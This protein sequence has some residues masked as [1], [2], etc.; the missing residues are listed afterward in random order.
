MA[1]VESL[2]AAKTAFTAGK[3]AF[4]WLNAKNKKFTM[5][6]EERRAKNLASRQAALGSGGE[7]MQTAA[8][9]LRAQTTDASKKVRANLFAA[10]LENSSVARVGQERIQNL[11]N[12]QL[13][14]LALKIADRNS[15]FLERASQRKE[16]INMQIGQ[17]R[18]QFEEGRKAEMRRAGSQFILSA[19]D[20]GIKGAQ[21]QQANQEVATLAA[22]S[23]VVGAEV[24]KI[25]TKLG[26]GKDDE[27]L[28]DLENLAQKEFEVFD[29][30]AIIKS[31]LS[32]YKGGKE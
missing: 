23:E 11:S 26:Q 22:E 1:I 16:A 2:V 32:I 8:N 6:P 18:R 31:L 19:L 15:Q 3:A 27:A 14:D 21:A 9:Q 10:G 12:N 20:L 25:A 7:S 13:A 24:E 30:T 17:R 28:V 5:T 4:D 29:I